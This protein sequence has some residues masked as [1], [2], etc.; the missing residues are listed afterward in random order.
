VYGGCSGAALLH[1][2]TAELVGIHTGFDHKKFEAQ[3]ITLEAI[4]A[5][6]GAFSLQHKII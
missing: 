5:F 2:E 1:G 6:V 4:N 3:A